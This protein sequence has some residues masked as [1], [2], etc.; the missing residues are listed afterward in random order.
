MAP[1][2]G[3]DFEMH[4]RGLIPLH[5]MLNHPMIEP[6]PLRYPQRYIG[7]ILIHGPIIFYALEA[8]YGTFSLRL[9]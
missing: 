4:L 6:L 9:L 7:T 3:P 1:P 5:L 2:A 8:E